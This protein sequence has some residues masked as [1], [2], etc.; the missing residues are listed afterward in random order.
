MGRKKP[1]ADAATPVR[2]YA[3]QQTATLLRRLAYEAGRTAKSGDAASVHDLRVAIRRL[4][5]CLRVF[6]QFFR[7]GVTKKIRRALKELADVASEV[8]NRD[9]ARALVAKAK[10]EP[11]CG[12]ERRLAEERGRAQRELAAKLREWTRSDRSRKWRSALDL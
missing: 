2:R 10:L 3:S 8:R 1:D 11:E 12:L 7:R 6:D 5:Q 4:A 9:V